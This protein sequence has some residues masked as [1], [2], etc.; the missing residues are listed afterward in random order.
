MPK[1]TC[2]VEALRRTGMQAYEIT[3]LSR[4]LDPRRH[5]LP[6]RVTGLKAVTACEERVTPSKFMN[7]VGKNTLEGA[8]LRAAEPGLTRPLCGAQIMNGGGSPKDGEKSRGP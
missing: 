6:Y 8:D 2:R 7:S 5:V 3:L 1:V 4:G